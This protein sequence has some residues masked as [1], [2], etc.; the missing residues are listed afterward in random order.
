VKG[1]PKERRQSPARAEPA[2][3]AIAPGP[4]LTAIQWPARRTDR[5]LN[6]GPIIPV[7]STRSTSTK[8]GTKF[9]NEMYIIGAHMDGHGWG[10][11]ATT[12]ARARRW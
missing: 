8:V 9:P 3:L 10:E 2:S 1:L 6:S 5:A 7:R 11:A 12:M 4:A